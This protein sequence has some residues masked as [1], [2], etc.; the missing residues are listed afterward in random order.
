MFAAV[1]GTSGWSA[2]GCQLERFSSDVSRQSVAAL[3]SQAMQAET[4]ATQQQPAGPPH[5]PVSGQLHDQPL[6]RGQAQQLHSAD[7]SQKWQPAAVTSEVVA[8]LDQH[9]GQP[10][11]LLGPHHAF[12]FADEQASDAQQQVSLRCDASSVLSVHQLLLGYGTVVACVSIGVT[13]ALEPPQRRFAKGCLVCAL[14][15]AADEYINATT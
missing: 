10:Q 15:R 7:Q 14:F 13:F 1:C 12:D 6:E 2:D 5:E 11:Y 3:P 9:Y 8:A 4:D